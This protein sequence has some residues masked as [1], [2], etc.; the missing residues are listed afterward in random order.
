MRKQNL[1]TDYSFF[2]DFLSEVFA[3]VFDNVEIINSDTTDS[4]KDKEEIIERSVYKDGECISH[5]KTVYKNGKIVSSE[6]EENTQKEIPS[7]TTECNK[8][9]VK[10]LQD[11]IEFL[12][13]EID[14]LSAKFA[15]L[16]EINKSLESKLEETNNGIEIM[17]NK[18]KNN[19]RR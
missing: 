4:K 7:S 14:I 9:K 19:L 17:L 11:R 13:K 8:D 2:K 15:R 10:E 12:T 16:K 3:E 5:E 6:G 1:N 18:F